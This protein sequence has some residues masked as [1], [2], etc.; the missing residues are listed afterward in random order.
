[1][2]HLDPKRL[3][4]VIY[5]VLHMHQFKKYHLSTLFL[6][7]MGRINPY[8]SP[9]W[10]QPVGIELR[11]YTITC[12]QD[13]LVLVYQ[14][15]RLPN[16]LKLIDNAKPFKVLESFPILQINLKVVRAS[17]KLTLVQKHAAGE[18]FA[19]IHRAGLV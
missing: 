9:T 18:F 2:D 10:Q 7:A 6:P 5:L 19:Q 17:V 12:G 1:M 13:V 3:G 4:F 14:I 15:N 11:Q 16:H 8:M